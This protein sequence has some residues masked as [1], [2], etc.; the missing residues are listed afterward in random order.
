MG[1]ALSLQN[2]NLKNIVFLS[3]VSQD[4]CIIVIQLY[5]DSSIVFFWLTTSLYLN[6]NLLKVSLSRLFRLK[7]FIVNKFV[8]Q[9]SIHRID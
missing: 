8:S 5:H 6:N 2:A 9:K 3:S 4:A 1:Q 7:L